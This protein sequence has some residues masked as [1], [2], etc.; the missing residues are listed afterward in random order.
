MLA[1]LPQILFR[2][3]RS[4]SSGLIKDMKSGWKLVGNV[5]KL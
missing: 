2:K 1:R 3:R 4:R 5:I